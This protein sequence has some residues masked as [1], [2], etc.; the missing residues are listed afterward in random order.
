VCHSVIVGRAFP[1]Y[2]LKFLPASPAPLFVASFCASLDC[3]ENCSLVEGGFFVISNEAALIIAENDKPLFIAGWALAQK[4]TD[5]TTG[6]G[7]L[8]CLHEQLGSCAIGEPT[9]RWHAYLRDAA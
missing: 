7:V 1:S 3:L 6:R 2:H 8:C 5:F 4:H 9:R